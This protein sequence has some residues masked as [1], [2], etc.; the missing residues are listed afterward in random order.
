MKT[1]MAVFTI[2][3]TA[4]FVWLVMKQRIFPF[5]MA[6]LSASYDAPQRL[7]S[8][9]AF[10]QKGSTVIYP[11]ALVVLS[12]GYLA[13]GS[14]A[15][16]LIAAGR[17]ADYSDNSDGIDGDAT[18]EVER[19]IFRYDNSTDSELI[20]LTCVGSVCFIVD[21]HTVAKTNGTNTR[22][23][24]GIVA[25]VDNNGVWVEFPPL[26]TG[27]GALLP[28]NNLNDVSLAATAR[29]NI[30]ANKLALQ[31]YIDDLDHTD[32]KVYRVVSPVAGTITLIKSVIDHALADGDA[33]LTGKIGSTGITNG[34][35]TI[36]QSGSA[37]GDVDTCSPSD[38]RTV[39]AGDVISI[40]VSGANTDTD[41]T[42]E[43]TIL[44][45]Y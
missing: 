35:I 3:A 34:A 32:A 28:A 26:A 43:V 37:A 33:T 44:I 8:T 29:T 4:A 12:S 45:A 21:D 24:A 39:A 17:A 16:G 20:D 15:T 9:L 41:A 42:A 36:T 2:L 31:L 23:A 7:G 38:N 19:G 40:T 11:G 22:S 13:P 25:D 5:A 1:F 18:V 6:A 27:T 30:G 14:T 10:P